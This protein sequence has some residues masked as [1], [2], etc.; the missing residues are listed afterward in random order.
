MYV[1]A[2]A[3]FE[4]I[5]LADGL[6]N[7]PAPTG[8]VIS[9]HSEAELRGLHKT[10]VDLILAARPEPDGFPAP[11]FAPEASFLGYV[12]RQAYGHIRGAIEEGGEPPDEWLAHK[13]DTIKG[14]VAD[15]F[16]IEAL[17]GLSEAREA[18]GELVRAAYCARGT[19]LAKGLPGDSMIDHLFR[20][21]DLLERA[22]DQEAFE[23]E[24]SVAGA[25]WL[26]DF[27]S[28]RHTK[29]GARQK[30]LLSQDKGSFDEIMATFL[31]D[32]TQSIVKMGLFGGDVDQ[33][34]IDDGIRLLVKGIGRYDPLELSYPNE[35]MRNYVR[36]PSS[37][38]FF[39]DI[40][41]L[42]NSLLCLA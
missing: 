31:G 39:L 22:D 21:Q 33:A 4:V 5:D 7:S 30:H 34:A 19:S 41:P 15:A 8:L 14:F 29:A 35:S 26:W 36:L 28:A 17:S 23:Y 11:A 20:A 32:Y 38:T 12:A 25:C 24:K 40:S 16:G 9:K 18:A 2:S 27:G 6:F 42:A 1:F 10:V 37:A 13:D 3:A